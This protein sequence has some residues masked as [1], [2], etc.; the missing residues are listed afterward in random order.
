MSSNGRRMQPEHKK[1]HVY[2]IRQL[3]GTVGA[4]LGSSHGLLHG[5][6]SISLEIL[7]ILDTAADTDQVVKDTDGLS[8][9][10]G[11]TSMCH[12][13]GQLDE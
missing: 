8:L 11:N 5:L 10:P 4:V 6:E 12:A 13:A 1:R 7:S 3:I 2:K 9:V